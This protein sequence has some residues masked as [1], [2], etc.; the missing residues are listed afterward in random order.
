MNKPGNQIAPQSD[1]RV[2]SLIDTTPIT[3]ETRIPFRLGELKQLASNTQDQALDSVVRCEGNV[4]L[5]FDDQA[6]IDRLSGVIPETLFQ[7]DIQYLRLRAAETPNPR[8]KARYLHAVA[9]LTRREDDG[10][11]AAEAYLDAIH[12]YRQ[13][14]PRDNFDAFHALQRMFP[15]AMVMARRHG[16][17]DRFK[18]EALTF[19]LDGPEWFVRVKSQLLE[20]AVEDS[21]RFM[22]EDMIRLRGFSLDLPLQLRGGYHE[23]IMEA[24]RI[25]RRLADRI[26]ESHV[27]WLEAEAA[28][29]E[30]R[31]ELGAHPMLVEIVG[32]RLMRLYQLLRN[33]AQRQITIKRMR[34]A[35][36]KIGYTVFSGQPDDWPEQVLTMQGLARTMVRDKGGIGVLHW[37]A[38]DPELIPRVSAVR[39]LVADMESRGI[40]TFRKLATQID[41]VGERIVSHGESGAQ[42]SDPALAETYDIAWMFDSVLKF[43][44]FIEELVPNGDID[45]NHLERFLTE[46]WIGR[47]ENISYGGDATMPNDLVR[48]LMAGLRLYFL[49]KTDKVHRD[50]LIPTLDT[51]TLRVE[52]MLRKLARLLDVPDTR[53]AD[54][55]HGRAIANVAGLELLDHPKIQALCGEDLIAFAKHTLDRKPEGLRDKVGHAIL[56]AVQYRDLDLDAV[57]LLILRLAGLSLPITTE[58]ATEN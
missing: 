45:L 32:T 43:S 48:L 41:S 31:L 35:R 37:L 57:V 29:L 9:A 19:L 33:D 17:F 21:R 54:D 49:I 53:P 20:L 56:H 23:E 15:V 26:Q 42:G 39:D 6:S 55:R 7:S 8:A 16:V 30:D 1:T 18:E 11:V 44:V 34:E 24:A 10:R 22:R 52:A 25:G 50:S 12:H 28:A 58:Q 38:A 14:E 47:E 27:P 51:L 40:G 46:S 36:S 2:S 3:E 4:F 5:I 13:Q